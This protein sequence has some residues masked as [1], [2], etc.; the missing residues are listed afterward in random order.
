MSDPNVRKSI[1]ARQSLWDRVETVAKAQGWPSVNHAVK[2]LL[3]QA[4]DALEGKSSEA[5]PAAP[6][7]PASALKPLDSAPGWMRR[8]WTTGRWS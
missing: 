2:E 3:T 7:P 5:E 6:P 1:L 8:G 4:M